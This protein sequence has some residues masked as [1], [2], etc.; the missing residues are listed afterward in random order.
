VPRRPAPAAGT[1][2]VAPP[3]PPRRGLFGIVT[4]AIRGTL[5]AAPAATPVTMPRAE[6]SIEEVQPARANVRPA[7]SG[8]EFGIDIPAFLRR[9]SS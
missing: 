9:Q 5:P 4:G 7:V 1:A 6:P 2:E 8:D 3:Q